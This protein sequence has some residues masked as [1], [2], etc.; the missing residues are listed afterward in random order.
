MTRMSGFLC[1]GVLS[2]ALLATPVSASSTL[3]RLGGKAASEQVARGSD[4]AL[5]QAVQELP[6]AAG[7]ALPDRPP[8]PA[9]LQGTADAED[10]M[11]EERSPVLPGIHLPA[12]MASKAQMLAFG[13]NDDLEAL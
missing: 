7:Q 13:D 6:G 4:L 10:S 5:V 8:A 2:V 1:A 12:A 3:L 11:H 9:A